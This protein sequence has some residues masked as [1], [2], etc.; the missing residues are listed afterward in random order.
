MKIDSIIYNEHK[1]EKTFPKIDIQERV[2]MLESLLSK[3]DHRLIK[4]VKLARMKGIPYFEPPVDL[5]ALPVESIEYPV[6]PLLTLTP[7]VNP[8][9]AEIKKF[10]K[11]WED[12]FHWDLVSRGVAEVRMKIE[13]C[14]T[15]SWEKLRIWR[16]ALGSQLGGTIQDRIGEEMEE[17]IRQ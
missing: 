3:E 17:F 14:Q 16:E 7:M 6:I 1:V 10:G 5:E 4:W 13:D 9:E 8:I 12:N 2:K 15:P 11:Y